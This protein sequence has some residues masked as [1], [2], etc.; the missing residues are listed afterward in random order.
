MNNINKQI[1]VNQNWKKIFLFILFILMFGFLI[2]W[3]LLKYGVIHLNDISIKKS[4]SFNTKLGKQTNSINI[5]D[6]EI[7]NNL[8]NKNKIEQQNADIKNLEENHSPEANNNFKNIINELDEFKNYFINNTEKNFLIIFANTAELR[9]GGGFIGVYGIL[10]TKNGKIENLKIDDVYNLDK[11]A[12]EN[13]FKKSPQPI[14]KYLNVKNLY[15][16]DA[17]WSP[18]FLENA[19]NLIEIYKQESGSDIN[20]DGVIS[21]NPQFIGKILDIYSGIEE[22][23]VVYNSKN[24]IDILEYKVEQEYAKLGI[25]ESKRKDIISHLGDTII[26]K[27][28]TSN[29]SQYIQVLSIIKDS[30]DKKDIMFYVKDKK[31]AEYLYFKN[32][33]GHLVNV[34]SDFIMVVDANLASLK[35]D[36][37]MQ[38]TLNYY[39]TK[40]GDTY[41]GNIK[42]IYE[43]TG[44]FDWKTTRYN[45]YTRVYLP[46][47]TKIKT[48]SKNIKPIFEDDSPES[49]NKNIIGF[50]FSI[51]PKQKQEV[52]IVYEILPEFVS[53]LNKKYSLYFQKQ[54]G[55]K[56]KILIDSKINDVIKSIHQN[57]FVNQNNFVF[58]LDKDKRILFD[59]K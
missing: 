1:K 5:V 7:K 31:L 56:I 21:I 38:K 8:S 17:N 42:L 59:L 53:K 32:W 15:F 22:Q 46:K 9:P 11:N 16:R 48:Y 33:D 39:I 2:F 40:Q 24:L 18:D 55:N 36:L 52:E 26:Q 45:T 19:K 14:E 6:N 34:N 20:F 30:L 49:K 51:E 10:K 50:Y 27:I 41:F 43:N 54:S 13:Y 4:Y 47:R 25:E 28:K 57:E 37:V 58:E 12:K 35:T 44:N 23:G 3:L 29:Y